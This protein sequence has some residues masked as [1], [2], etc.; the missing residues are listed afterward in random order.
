VLGDM[1]WI[2][3]SDLRA[4]VEAFA[5]E[6]GRGICAPVVDRKR[7][8]PVLWSAR[9]FAELQTLHGDVGARHLLAEHSEDVCEVSVSGDGVLRDIDTPEALDASPADER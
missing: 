4:L 8:N 6:E 9:Y 1:P 2:S 5:P 3:A 7:G